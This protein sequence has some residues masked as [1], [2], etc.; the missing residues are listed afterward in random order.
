MSGSAKRFG[1]QLDE[2]VKLCD[3]ARRRC[4]TKPTYGERVRELVASAASQGMT[5]SELFRVTKLSK[6]Y[7]QKVISSAKPRKIKPA[8][9]LI[10]VASEPLAQTEQRMILSLETCGFKVC[11]YTTPGGLR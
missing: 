8:V 7:L 6:S 3:A 2:L 11:V 4:P 10:N 1:P 5:V 9:Q